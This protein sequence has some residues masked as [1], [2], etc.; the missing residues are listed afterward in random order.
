MHSLSGLRLTPAV[1]AIALALP[2]PALSQMEGHGQH[3][4]AGALG[5]SMDRMGSGT[6]WI[7]EDVSL[8][9]RHFSRGPWSVML[10]GFVFAQY[11]KQSGTR[12]DSQ[13]GSLN[14]GM[15]M[16]SRPLAGGVFQART[17]L[18]LDPWTVTD[19]GYPLLAQ[20]G[21]TY[22]G[23]LLY[24]RQHPHDF[25]MEVAALYERPITSNLA[26]S[27]YAGP[28]GEPALGPVA[29]MHR[30]S[31]MD[32]PTAPLGHHWQD[33]THISYG[34]A[35][36]GLFT[37]RWKLEASAFNGREPDERRF[38]MDQP[39]IDSYSARLTANPNKNWSAT[40]GF[41]YLAS[42]ESLHPDEAVHRTVGSLMHGRSFRN[43]LWSSTLVVG[44]NSHA[45]ERST[46][47]LLESQV[48]FGANT[49]TAR[50]ELTG[51]TGEELALAAVPPDESFR[52]A[53][54]SLGYI[55]DFA[56]GARMTTGIG[57]RGTIH[58]MPAGLEPHYGS[59]SPTGLILF[60]RVRPVRS[61]MMEM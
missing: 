49:V 53:A 5:I 40:I 21:E 52:V 45:G 36:V 37:R 39:R 50:A 56:R 17:M 10:H 51:R 55:R 60:L 57:A 38:A 48:V 47:T 25:W 29:F 34:V 54:L 27:L 42:P 1:L 6:T 11:N 31:A 43:G 32:D 46:S 59:R 20:T 3:M 9:S 18:S 2:T 7:P 33:A 23:A 61:V 35:T 13:F 15:L 58:A 4:P 8:P 30:V 16:A 22:K 28:S 14:W 19:R 26:L 41:G 44:A 12:G 24:D